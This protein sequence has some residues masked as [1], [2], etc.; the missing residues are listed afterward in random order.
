MEVKKKKQQKPQKVQK[1]YLTGAMMDRTVMPG[2]LK[3]FFST[4]V[5]VFAFVMIGVM[6]TWDNKLLSIVIN[7]VILFTAWLIFYQSGAATG[8]DA[9]N[10]GE[11][12]YQRREKGRPVADWEQQLCYHPLKGFVTGLIGSIP[13]VLCSVVFALITQ[14][15]MTNLGTLPSWLTSL[16]TRPEIGGALQYYHASGS[17]T[18]ESALRLIIRMSTMPY[19]NMIGAADKDAMLVLERIS[20][21]L[22]LI[23]AL[24]YGLGYMG[25]VQ[26]RSAVHT[27][28]ALGKK[29][30]KRK[31][32]KER[33][34]RQQTHR[35][36][37]QLN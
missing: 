12:M 31:Q 15:Q 33:K 2:A 10:Q 26:V 34:A 23:P 36:P 11:I 16:E 28:I 5:M 30:A 3:F 25:G 8:A 29:K 13:L 9:V 27:N 6:M 20:P 19:V 24:V 7:S 18:L 21:M 4:V 14:R 22:N 32:R 37:E 35:G 17:M 1:P